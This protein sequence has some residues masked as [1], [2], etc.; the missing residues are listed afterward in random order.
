M[1]LEKDSRARLAKSVEESQRLASAQ[2]IA[3]AT[4]HNI[5]K[6]FPEY[7]RFM[8]RFNKRP[9]V[10]TQ[11]VLN[12]Q[13]CKSR[14]NIPIPD[15]LKSAEQFWSEWDPSSGISVAPDCITVSVDD[16]KTVCVC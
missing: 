13:S 10:L 12:M 11:K 5:K 1:Q 9:R 16:T 4:H 2:L 8:S 15:D 7:L 6:S 14:F 3:S